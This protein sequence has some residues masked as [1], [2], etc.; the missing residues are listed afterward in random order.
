MFVR[1]IVLLGV[2]LAG[3]AAGVHIDEIQRFG[4]LDEK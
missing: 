3:V 1:R 2:P 4:R